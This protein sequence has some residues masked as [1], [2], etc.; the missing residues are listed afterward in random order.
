[1][2]EGLKYLI[3]NDLNNELRDLTIKHIRLSKEYNGTKCKKCGFVQGSEYKGV[4]HSYC[5]HLTQ[6]IDKKIKK[7]SIVLTK[8]IFIFSSFLDS[9]KVV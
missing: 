4:R 6:K 5:E 3:R 2:N 8:K 1:M 9:Q 7:E